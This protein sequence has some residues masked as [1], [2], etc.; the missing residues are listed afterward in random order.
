M[1]DD[2][3]IIE[4]IARFKNDL[5]L[6]NPPQLVRKYV[7]FGDAY[8]LPDD[9]FFSLKEE[10]AHHFQVHPNQ[11]FLVGSAKLGFSIARRKRYRPFTDTSDIDVAVVSDR[12]FDG[13]WEDVFRYRYQV[14]YW[15]Q[16]SEFKNYLFRGWIR[17]DKLP[18]ANSFRLGAEWWAFFSELTSSGRYGVYKI[19]AGLYRSDFFFESYQSICVSECQEEAR[20][21]P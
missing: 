20:I 4:R 10:V 17:P 3:V 18:P 16:E 21:Q 8:I 1:P 9:Q 19:A 5:A 12:L 13:I 7:A 15:P 2:P 6:M 11:V 14:G